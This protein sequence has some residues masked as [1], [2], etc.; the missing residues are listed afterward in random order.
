MGNFPHDPFST[1][2]CKVKH[3]S[4]TKWC[5]AALLLFFL[6]W[7][8][9]QVDQGYEDAKRA[10]GQSNPTCPTSP[11]LADSWG[12]TVSTC[13][14]TSYV[15]Y[16]LNLNEV[17]HGGVL[18]K[19]NWTS[20]VH[21]GHAYNWAVAAASVGVRVDQFPAV[22]SV[23][24]WGID[25][26]AGGFGHVA[27]V[28]HIFTHRADGRLDGIGIME[29]NIKKHRYTYRRIGVRDK[30][31]PRRFLH[32]EE[33]GRDADKTNVTCVS[34]VGGADGSFCWEHNGST[35]ECNSGSA[36]YYFNYRTCQ[37]QST[38][39]SFCSA[40]NTNR[41]YKAWLPSG[42]SSFPEPIDPQARGNDFAFC[43]PGQSTASGTSNNVSGRTAE[44]RSKLWRKLSVLN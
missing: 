37:K 10:P 25:E 5:F 28:Q 2:D 31:Y 40:L 14:C 22:G 43:A 8:H 38:N 42:D 26:I 3:R 39:S 9:A 11:N 6:P 1:E 36:H 44:A 27:Y 30:G 12:F 29:Y 7:V 24:H 21:F 32:F 17:K 41:G 33:K 4:L 18:F 19:N 34:G 20:G 13:E 23:A 35:V 16:R 15:A